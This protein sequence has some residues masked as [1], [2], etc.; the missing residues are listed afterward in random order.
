MNTKTRVVN[1]RMEDYDV[2][3]GRGSIFGNPYTH[4]SDRPTLAKYVVATRGEAIQKYKEYFDKRIKEDENF[5]K[6]F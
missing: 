3:I 4:I 6:R 2:Y 1:L 5:K